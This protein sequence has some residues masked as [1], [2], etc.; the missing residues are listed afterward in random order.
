MDVV[1]SAVLLVSARWQ[2]IHLPLP[3]TWARSLWR[4]GC[5][6]VVYGLRMCLVLRMAPALRLVF[7]IARVGVLV[8]IAHRWV[9]MVLR[10]VL[11]IA[12]LML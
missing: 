12:Q 11:L 9:V 2:P 7:L 8:L 3:V 4:R 10:Q 5:R 1:W 6:L